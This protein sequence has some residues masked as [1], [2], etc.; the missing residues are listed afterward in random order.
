MFQ[1]KKKT[2][3][4]FWKCAFLP[5][6]F[7]MKSRQTWR[8]SQRVR[9]SA[10]ASLHSLPPPYFKVSIERR[11][12]P[13]CVNHTAAW[14]KKCQEMEYF[15]TKRTVYDSRYLMCSGEA[16]E[17]GINVCAHA[18]SKVATQK[19]NRNWKKQRELRHFGERKKKKKTTALR[20]RFCLKKVSTSNL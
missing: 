8:C 18:S 5:N 2:L 11:W 9:C 14:A 15:I 6:H 12:Q 3:F 19:T 4:S 10:R 16:A 13:C 1:K 20:G 7:E 17:A